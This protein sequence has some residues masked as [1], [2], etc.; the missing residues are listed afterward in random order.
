MQ[1]TQSEKLN[2]CG[3]EVTADEISLIRQ[4]VADYPKLSQ[5]ELALGLRTRF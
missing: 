2:F 3:R 1:V 4:I 5:T